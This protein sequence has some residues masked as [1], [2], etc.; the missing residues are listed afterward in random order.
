MSRRGPAEA[1]GDARFRGTPGHSGR[2]PRGGRS[3]GGGAAKGTWGRECRFLFLRPS[4]EG[5]GRRDGER[6]LTRSAPVRRRASASRPVPSRPRSPARSV[7]A[8]L[9]GGGS[10]SNCCNGRSSRLGPPAGKQARGRTGSVRFAARALS[11]ARGGAGKEGSGRCESCICGGAAALGPTEGP[12]P[13]A[14]GP[15]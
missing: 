13:G 15:R 9:A 6:L 10:G 11:R 3:H 2:G 14:A 1:G 4:P 7:S 5:A 12:E 8:A